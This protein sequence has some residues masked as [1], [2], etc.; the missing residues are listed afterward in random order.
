MKKTFW[1]ALL[2]VIVSGAVVQAY[3]GGGGGHGSHG[4]WSG[5]GSS[6]GGGG[7]VSHESWSGGAHS[8]WGG[9][10]SSH[11]GWGSHR[12][13]WDGGRHWFW[14][15]SGWGWYDADWYGG[16]YYSAVTGYYPPVG[17]VLTTVPNSC[18]PVSVDGVDYYTVNGVT[19][20]Q[21][22]DG[23]YQVVQPPR[24]LLNTTNAPALSAP[25][26]TPV[27]HGPD[28]AAATASGSLTVNIPS[29]K[30]GYVPVTLTLSGTGFIGPQGEFYPEFPKLE[31]LQAIYGK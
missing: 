24:A 22:T 26:Q 1:K 28:A 14:G 20:A 18:Q 29:A 15:G 6:H 8:I 17:T 2:T 19:Y 4:G 11:G 27:A 30:G 9:G 5:G 25:A 7:A 12:G 13:W 21:T 16:P 3:H 31:L 23:N 10:A